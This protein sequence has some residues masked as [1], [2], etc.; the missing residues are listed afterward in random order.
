MAILPLITSALSMG[1]LPFNATVGKRPCLCIFFNVVLHGSVT[2]LLRVGLSLLISPTFCLL[3]QVVKISRGVFL[4]PITFP[5][6]A[7]H[8][9]KIGAGKRMFL[10]I[11]SLSLSP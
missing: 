3:G 8:L 1:M 10:S 7:K 9:Y 5:M 11:F 6:H 4:R 2:F